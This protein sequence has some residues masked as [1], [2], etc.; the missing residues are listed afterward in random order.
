MTADD[1]QQ[2]G[3]LPVPVQP[4]QPA[5]QAVPAVAGC[6]PR[7]LPPPHARGGAAAGALRHPWPPPRVRP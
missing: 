6:G 7:R 3:L 5:Q 1:V 2:H 4:G